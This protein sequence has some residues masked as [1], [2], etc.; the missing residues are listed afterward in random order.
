MNL[1]ISKIIFYILKELKTPLLV[2]FSG[3]SFIMIGLSLTPGYNPNTEEVYYLSFFESF[4]IITYTS[5]TIGYGELPYPFTIQQKM[6]LALSIYIIVFLWFYLLSSFAD[7]F[8]KSKFKNIIKEYK[9]NKMIY[10]NKINILYVNEDNLKAIVHNSKF[11]EVTF[12]II[13]KG[14]IKI[15][16]LP[17]NCMLFEGNI[18]DLFI[19]EPIIENYIYDVN[20][21]EAEYMAEF[22]QLSNHAFNT[23]IFSIKENVN[24]IECISNDKIPNLEYGNLFKKYITFENNNIYKICFLDFLINQDKMIL[25]NIQK[26]YKAEQNE[27][28]K[29]YLNKEEGEPEQNEKNTF[30]MVDGINQIINIKNM[31]KITK[32][33]D[34]NEYIIF[35]NERKQ[36]I[37]NYI[38]LNDNILLFNTQYIFSDLVYKEILFNKIYLQLWNDIVNNKIDI[39]NIIKKVT[40]VKEPRILSYEVN[41]ENAPNITTPKIKYI[42]VL[43]DN[44]IVVSIK[45]ENNKRKKKGDYIE[46]GDKIFFIIEEGRFNQI[47][48]ILKNPNLKF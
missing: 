33:F 22:I 6:Y 17:E 21:E 19:Y 12:I 10:K 34:K 42:D 47:D 2:F 11:D 20:L 30:Y 45:K 41:Q 38:E 46:V 39:I 9:L 35:L 40:K 15:N 23:K 13:D 27:Y 3:F 5:T 25:K 26:I 16:Y 14:Q 4:Y 44:D 8:K 29:Q 48:S 36:N 1:N 24:L 37:E 7:I 28:K 31:I 18:N 43:E 32:N